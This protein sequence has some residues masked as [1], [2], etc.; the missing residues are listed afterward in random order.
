[1]SIRTVPGSWRAL[2]ISAA[3]GT[4]CMHTTLLLLLHIAAVLGIIRN[5]AGTFTN[6]GFVDVACY[7]NCWLGC[8]LLSAFADSVVVENATATQPLAAE[9]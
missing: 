8:L 7:L 1:M 5:G 6:E 9:F 3:H 4:R 2:S